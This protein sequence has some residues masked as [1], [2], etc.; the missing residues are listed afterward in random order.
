VKQMLTLANKYGMDHLW[1]WIIRHV[2][3]D[4]PQPLWQWD[5]LEAEILAMEETWCDE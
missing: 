2:E 4:W 1:D 5:M 3:A